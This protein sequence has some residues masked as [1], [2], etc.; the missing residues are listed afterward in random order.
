MAMGSQPCWERD[1]GTPSELND[2][3]ALISAMDG[4]VGWDG[5]S[6]RTLLT[7]TIP[8]V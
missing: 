5:E 3:V 7:L 1:V 6:Q 2:S 4:W 8:C